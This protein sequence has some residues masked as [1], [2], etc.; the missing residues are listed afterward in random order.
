MSYRHRLE[1]ILP[2]LLHPTSFRD[3]FKQE[4]IV[5]IDRVCIDSEAE[6][7]EREPS[8]DDSDDSS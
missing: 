3:G 6:V 4:K 5:V 2:L 7:E 8:D 1:V